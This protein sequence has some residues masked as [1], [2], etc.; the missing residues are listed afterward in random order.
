VYSLSIQLSL[1]YNSQQTALDEE[2]SLILV[3]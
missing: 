1:R 2:F 3:N